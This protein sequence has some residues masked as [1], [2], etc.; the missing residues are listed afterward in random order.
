MVVG[1]HWRGCEGLDSLRMQVQ[2]TDFWWLVIVTV[3]LRD[4]RPHNNMHY[5]WALFV[6]IIRGHYTRS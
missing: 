3:R 5:S 1:G 4:S 6:G 2:R